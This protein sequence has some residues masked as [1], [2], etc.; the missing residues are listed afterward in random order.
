MAKKKFLVCAYFA[1]NIGDDLF[2]KILFD[3]YPNVEWDLMTANRNYKE[4]FNEYE[5]VNIVYTYRNINFGKYDFNL[6]FKLNEILLNYNKYEGLINLGGSIFMESPAWRMKKDERKYLV[7]KFKEKNKKTFILGA[8]FGPFKDQNFVEEYKKLFPDYDDICFRDN[9][10]YSIFNDL[11]NVRVAPDIVFSL[12]KFYKTEPKEKKI[13]FSI[14]NLSKREGLKEF[15]DIYNQKIVQ[16]IEKYIEL[17]YKINLFSFCEN[18]G[19]LEIINALRDKVSTDKKNA[20]VVINYEG[21]INPFL[22]EFKTCELIIGSRFH[23]VILS[24]LFEQAVYPLI[25]SDKTYN[26]LKDLGMEDVCCYIKDIEKLD[27]DTVISTALKNKLQ[28]K[29]ILKEAE[30][31]FEKLDAYIG[32]S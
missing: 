13:G 2:L 7:E 10:S 30:K 19:D 23:S 16:L 29:T 18:E 21:N 25:Y 27:I 28:N 8:N 24:L 5:N 31:H 4:I 9:Y 3:R 20:L 17:G 22:E 11:D 26:V 32:K 14:I 15:Q 1:K 6:F 12:G